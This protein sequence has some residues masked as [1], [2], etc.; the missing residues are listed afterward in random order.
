MCGTRTGMIGKIYSCQILDNE[1]LIRNFI[2]CYS[3]TTV[4]D[5]DRKECSAGTVGLY[6]TV[7]GKFYTNQGTG[8]FGYETEDGTYVAPKNN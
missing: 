8:K 1:Q 5:V 2:P 7:E 3:T 4:T 6:D